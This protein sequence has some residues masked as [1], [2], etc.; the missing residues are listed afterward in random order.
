MK[1]ELTQDHMHFFQRLD[2]GSPGTERH[3]CACR[4]IEHPRRDDRVRVIGDAA[5]Q[6][7]LATPH[8]T[9]W[10]STSEPHAGCHG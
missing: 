1:T 5:N 7:A 10:T 4:R 9:V 3:V 2:R 6:D 8:F